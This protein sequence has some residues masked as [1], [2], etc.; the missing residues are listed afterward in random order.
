MWALISNE[1][2]IN[3]VDQRSAQA[4]GLLRQEQQN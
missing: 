3:K 4:N 2:K 1:I